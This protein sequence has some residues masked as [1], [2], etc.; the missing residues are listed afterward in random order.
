MVTRFLPTPNM[1]YKIVHKEMYRKFEV[2]LGLNCD[3]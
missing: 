3:I 1:Y 2:N